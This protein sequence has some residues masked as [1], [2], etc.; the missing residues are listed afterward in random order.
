MVNK[1][2]LLPRL[3]QQMRQ[4]LSLTFIGNLGLPNMFTKTSLN[5]LFLLGALEI[6]NCKNKNVTNS[7]GVLF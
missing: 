1:Y 4:N 6:F 2:P 3:W 7:A 5:I